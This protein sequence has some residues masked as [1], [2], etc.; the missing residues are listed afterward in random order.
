M[1]VSLTP[2]VLRWARE[3][4]G[5]DQRTLAK[6]VTGKPTADRVDH[7]EQTGMLT[8]AQVRKLA[9]ATHTPEG[10]L[11]LKE[12]PDDRLP[13]PDFRTVG[14]GSVKRPSPDLL[15]TAYMMRRRQTWMHDFLVEEDQPR[16][17]FVGSATLNSNPQKVAS[18]MRR[19]LGVGGGWANESTRIDALMRLR[20]RIEAAGILIVING[21]VGNNNHRKLDPNEFRRFV[22]SDVYAPLVFINGAD[23]KA[24]Q[25]FTITHEVA[26]LWINR[27]GVSNFEA[28]Q[29]PPIRVEQWCSQV[30]AEFLVPASELSEAW[31]HV[32]HSA[33][34]Y[35]DLAARFKVSTIV[36][37]R[38]VLDLGLISKKQFFKFYD[39]YQKDERRRKE[40]KKK[41]GGDFWNT[42]SVRVGQRFGT[43]VA[44]AAREGRLLYR[45][46]YQLTGLSG[47]TFDRFAENLGFR[48]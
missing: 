6:K 47:K 42:Q 7:W 37:A 17:G 38:R 30:A 35:Q 29:P 28:M 12:P 43:A 5:L 46:A 2:K 31:E 45:E 13:I 15:D 21:V 48:I 14:D 32:R 10:F 22:L 39:D 18:E 11:Y 27:E 33:E 3:R 26:H 24:A 9:H 25:M 36:A 41:K 44:R 40:A 34:P 23:F 8:F 19:T 1:N 20:H 4:A 16:L